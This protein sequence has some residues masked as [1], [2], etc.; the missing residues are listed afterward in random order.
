MLRILAEN[1]GCCSTMGSPSRKRT[2]FC[3]GLLGVP[4]VEQLGNK[5]THEDERER[6]DR[7]HD[8]IQEVIPHISSEEI[9]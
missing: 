9:K 4:R 5:S 6:H 1:E 3:V 8:H 2:A 7:R